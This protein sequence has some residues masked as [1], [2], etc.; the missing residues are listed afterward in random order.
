[1]IEECGRRG[2]QVSGRSFDIVT[3]ANAEPWFSVKSWF[4]VNEVRERMLVSYSITYG[5]VAGICE[6]WC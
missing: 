5:R 6:S 1:M 2:V 3:T 4:E